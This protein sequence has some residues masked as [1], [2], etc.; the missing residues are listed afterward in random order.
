[1]GSPCSPAAR[2]RRT[3]EA[4]IRSHRQHP[5]GRR[6]IARAWIKRNRTPENAFDAFVSPIASSLCGILYPHSANGRSIFDT[7]RHALH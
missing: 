5:F 7:D 2:L 6:D 1:M 4:V 3:V